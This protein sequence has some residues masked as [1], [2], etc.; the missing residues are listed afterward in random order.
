ML[1]WAGGAGGAGALLSGDIVQVIPDRSHVS[2]LWSYPNQV[3]LHETAVLEI[4]DQLA[5]FGFDELYGAWWKTRIGPG[6]KG[7]VERSV[8]RC[9]RALRGEGEFARTKA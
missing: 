1:H 9:V 8:E 3:P 5:P 2:F 7:I 6:A 4:G